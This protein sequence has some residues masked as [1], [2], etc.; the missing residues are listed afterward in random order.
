M[1][2][3]NAKTYFREYKRKKRLDPIYREQEAQKQREYRATNKEKTLLS[4]RNSERKRR[5]RRYNISELEYNQLFT[6]Q[7]FCC[8][9]CGTQSP[10]TKSWHLDHCHKTGKVRGILCHHCNLMLGNAKDNL[11]TLEKGILYLKGFSNE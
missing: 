1:S 6:N 11:Q 2:S 8:A 9:I 7:R 3:E 5:L 10:T 4:G